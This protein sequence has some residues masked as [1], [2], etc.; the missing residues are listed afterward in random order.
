MRAIRAQRFLFACNADW[1]G[2]AMLGTSCHE[3]VRNRS[4]P[5]SPFASGQACAGAAALD[6]RV[7]RREIAPLLRTLRTRMERAGLQRPAH[8][9]SHEVPAGFGSTHLQACVAH[10]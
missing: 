1:R 5:V 10:A 6:E 3:V 7:P 9:R 8:G 2:I 4:R